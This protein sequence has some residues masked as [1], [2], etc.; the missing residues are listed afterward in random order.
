MH[1]I[2]TAV[3]IT[4]LLC[5]PGLALDD[6]FVTPL[7]VD[8]AAPST[9]LTGS[10]VTAPVVDRAALDGAA[11][12]LVYPGRTDPSYSGPGWAT[13]LQT[14]A[15]RSYGIYVARLRPARAPGSVGVVSAFFTYFND[16]L[17]HDGDGL[18]DNHEID[19]EFVAAE[20]SVIYLT[21]WTAYQA[22][23]TGELFRKVTRKVNLR[24]GRVWQ[25]P[26]GGE[27]TY[28]LVEIE[29]LG[30]RARRFIA[31]NAYRTYRFDW[32]PT[33]VTFAVDLEDGHGVRTL[34]DLSGAPNVVIPSHPAP[35]FLN[36][37]H[38]ASHWHT[39]RPARPPFLQVRFRVDRVDI[40]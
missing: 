13:E 11:L 4:V 34:W 26:P 15:T 10:S 39:G 9:P 31:A 24:T 6:N 22:D 36:L 23:A 7:S 33:A 3:L 18:I 32:E 20:P 19:Y 38:N 37:W 1:R 30:W 40:P 17:D 29:P 25:T 28:D 27:G 14:A 16:G 12:E 2:A 35:C 8:W 5:R 21:V